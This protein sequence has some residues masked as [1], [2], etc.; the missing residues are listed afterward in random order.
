MIN[1]SIVTSLNA[2]QPA[3]KDV[4]YQIAIMHSWKV[5]MSCNTYIGHQS[6]EIDCR[7]AFSACYRSHQSQPDTVTRLLQ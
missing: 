7:L 4:N 3:M 6:P 5:F 2:H 1:Y